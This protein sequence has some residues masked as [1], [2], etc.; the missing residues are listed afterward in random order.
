MKQQKLEL[1]RRIITENLRVQRDGE[2]INYISIGTALQDAQTRQNHTVFA[3]RGCGKTLLLHHSSRILSNDVRAVYL[4]CEDFKRHT[5]PNVLIEILVALFTEIE[6]H[7]TGWFGRKRQSK[8]IIAGIIDRLENL[9]SSEDVQSAAVKET[10]S[11]SNGHATELRGH[12]KPGKAALLASR[13]S[14]KQRKKEVERTFDTYREKISELD[15]W[16]PDLKKEIRTFFKISKQVKAIFL[17]I[18]DLYHLRR[19]DQAL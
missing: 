2:D 17:Q 3:R 12:V 14:S 19:T 5:F 9:Q 13:Q 15:R 4:N 18:D 1:L 7:L 16:L 10:A 11:A 8:E 6:S